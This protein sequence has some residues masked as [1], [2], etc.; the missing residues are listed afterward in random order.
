MG[1]DKNTNIMDLKVEM[2]EIRGSSTI[3]HKI[4]NQLKLTCSEY[5]IADFFEYV[6]S[7]NKTLDP[8]YIYVKTGF[9]I[10]S[11]NYLRQQLRT[12]EII[13]PAQNKYGF[14]LTDKW[15]NSLSGTIDADFE[16]FWVIEDNSGK[17]ITTWPGSKKKAKEWYT[18]RIKRYGKDYL[19]KQKKEYLLY[20]SRERNINGFQRTMMMASKFLGNDEHFSIK[21]HEQCKIPIKA[22]YK[23]KKSSVTKEDYKDLY[24]KK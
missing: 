1:V 14:K 2:P 18:K 22:G 9:D 3:N 24:E 15:L 10:E 13:E 8:G 7:N 16:D 12:K 17:R 11:Y 5:A 23:P 21:W 6:I 20:L 19:N 4:R